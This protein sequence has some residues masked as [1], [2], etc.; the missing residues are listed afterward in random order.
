MASLEPNPQTL[1]ELI[2]VISVRTPMYIGEPTIQRLE[3]F[4][5][6]WC[7]AKQFVSGP[8]TSTFSHWVQKKY[9]IQTSHSWASIIRFYEQ[10]DLSATKTAFELFR[11]FFKEYDAD[12]GDNQG[13]ISS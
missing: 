6:G 12:D 11:E 5:C 10:D 4:L 7:Y 1:A 2:E 9:D 3:A 8:D 13:S